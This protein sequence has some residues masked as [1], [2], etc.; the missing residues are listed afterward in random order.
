MR[1]LRQRRGLLVALP[2]H[3]RH[4]YVYTEVA[5]RMSAGETEADALA[6]LQA[7]LD[8]HARLPR[9]GGR[10]RGRTPANWAGLV[11]ELQAANPRRAPE[12][13]PEADE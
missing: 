4:S 13:E 1:D 8:A 6:G 5:R 2:R 12:A 9:E 11:Q 10:G 7:R 3:A